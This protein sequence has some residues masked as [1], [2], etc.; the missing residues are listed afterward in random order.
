VVFGECAESR[1]DPTSGTLRGIDGEHFDKALFR[2]P[3][4]RSELGVGAR[5]GSRVLRRSLRRTESCRRNGSGRDDLFGL[6]ERTSMVLVGVSE[7][8]VSVG[9]HRIVTRMAAHEDEAAK[10][11][12]CE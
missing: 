8:V 5:Y 12:E 3:S 6:R 2:C 7:G 11:K 1:F 9:V 10:R 4:R